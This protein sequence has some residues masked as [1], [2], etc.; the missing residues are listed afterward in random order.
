MEA[1]RIH[2]RSYPAINDD[3]GPEKP[4]PDLC[5]LELRGQPAYAFSKKNKQFESPEP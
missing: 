4:Y 1:E 5:L 2:I 3:F